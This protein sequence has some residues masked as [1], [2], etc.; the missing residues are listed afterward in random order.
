MLCF[1]SHLSGCVV[2]PWHSCVF[3][4]MPRPTQQHC[5]RFDPELEHWPAPAQR[6]HTFKYE[7]TFR[8]TRDAEFAPLC[9]VPRCG[10]TCEGKYQFHGTVESSLSDTMRVDD[11]LLYH[12]VPHTFSCA[13]QVVLL[14]TGKFRASDGSHTRTADLLKHQVIANAKLKTTVTIALAYV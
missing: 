3:G 4:L 14:P 2:S 7:W 13:Q 10:G 5:N 9:P 11:Y 6:Y 1:L 8:I 12:N